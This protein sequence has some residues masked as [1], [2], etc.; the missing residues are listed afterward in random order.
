MTGRKDLFDES[1]HLGHSAAWDLEWDRAIEFYRKAL[2]EIPDE[3]NAL[4]S[5]GLAL[6]ETEK[7]K[8]SLDVYHHATKLDPNNPVPIEKSAEILERMGQTNA[9]V[10]QRRDAAEQHLLRKDAE[11]AIENWVH[12]ARITPDDRATRSRLALTYE[13]LGRKQ[14]AIDEY[15]ALASIIQSTGNS[16][17]AIDAIQRALRIIP[18]DKDATKALKMA[19][20]VAVLPSGPS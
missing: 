2:A 1:M 6:L 5:L 3:I 8:E 20:K 12:I 17:Q 18:A 15:L 19:Q 13:R 16:D 14:D 7:Y 4:T 9:A 11:K 10:E